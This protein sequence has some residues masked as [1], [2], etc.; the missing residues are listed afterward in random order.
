MKKISL[1]LF[2]LLSLMIISCQKDEEDSSNNN[3]SSG[4]NL[5]NASITF[6]NN[7]S[8]SGSFVITKPEGGLVASSSVNAHQSIVLHANDGCIQ[9]IKEPGT[10][11]WRLSDGYHKDYPSGMFSIYKDQH[12]IISY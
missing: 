8:W 4:G 9:S 11:K 3:S 10:Y 6:T 5:G 7:E 1:S 2:I 12:L